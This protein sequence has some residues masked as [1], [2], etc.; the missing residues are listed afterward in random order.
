MDY[1]GNLIKATVGDPVDFQSK[2]VPKAVATRLLALMPGQ[3]CELPDFE[4]IEKRHSVTILHH[5]TVGQTINEYHTNLDGCGYVVAIAEDAAEAT[6]RAENA[7]K[8][9]E[10][11]IIRR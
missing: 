11:S 7:L 4:A 3:V 1:L 8:E 2:S 6:R 9:I 10:E 5:L